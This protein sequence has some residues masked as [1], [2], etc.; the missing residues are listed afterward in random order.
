MIMI[1]LTS[2]TAYILLFLVDALSLSLYLL[3]AAFDDFEL[4]NEFLDHCGVS[5]RGDVTYAVLFVMSYFTKNAT[6]NLARACLRQIGVND[7]IWSGKRAYRSPDRI[8]QRA[9]IYKQKHKQILNKYTEMRDIVY[10]L[11]GEFV[12]GSESVLEN[13]EADDA[14]ALDL[15]RES[16]HGRFRHLRTRHQ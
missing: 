9:L 4:L 15:M 13:D 2:L 11:R 3:T 5:Q 1:A 6:H 10:F 7:V 12:G 8:L 16:H 14:L